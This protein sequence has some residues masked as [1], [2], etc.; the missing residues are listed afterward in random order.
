MPEINSELIDHR[1][2]EVED[3]V[4]ALTISVSELT[5]SV[6]LLANSMGIVKWISAIAGSSVV[7]QV[8]DLLFGK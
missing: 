4:K 5:T 6:K 1:L 2:K 7:V 3:D 8:I